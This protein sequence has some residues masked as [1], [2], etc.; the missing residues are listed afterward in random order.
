MKVIKISIYNH[1]AASTATQYCITE[2]QF[3]ETS[4]SGETAI[5]LINHCPPHKRKVGVT[6][7]QNILS[8]DTTRKTCPISYK[9]CMKR[10]TLLDFRNSDFNWIRPLM[11][12]KVRVEK[13]ID[14]S[15]HSLII[16][17]L[18]FRYSILYLIDLS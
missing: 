6:T 8:L 11:G 9:R 2:K 13:A 4:T 16:Y 12:I 1:K 5:K 18:G 7:R 14:T 3:Q 15:L 17:R 10:N